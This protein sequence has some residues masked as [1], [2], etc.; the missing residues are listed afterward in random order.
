MLSPFSLPEHS[1]LYTEAIQLLDNCLAQKNTDRLVAFIQ[2]QVIVEPPDLDFLRDFSEALSQRVLALRT[3]L[4]D[5]RDNVV[6]VFGKDYNIDITPLTPP[7]AIERYYTL[8]PDKVIAYIRKQ[9][10]LPSDNDLRML[11]KLL[12]ISLM[13]ASRITAEVM[14]ARELEA[15]VR[16]WQE[17]LSNSLGRRSW[18]EEQSRQ[19]HVH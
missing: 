11:T 16:D 17:A 2:Q 9:P 4:Y 14:L 3:N 6:R 8:P 10:N 1:Q 18:P 13:T 7:N 19:G 5:I 15:L 12:E